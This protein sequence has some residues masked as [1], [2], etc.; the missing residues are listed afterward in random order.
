MDEWHRFGAHLHR[1]VMSQGHK[2]TSGKLSEY[3]A[4]V[5]PQAEGKPGGL[6]SYKKQV[7]ASNTAKN[8]EAN[9]VAHNSRQRFQGSSDWVSQIPQK[10]HIRWG[11][12]SDNWINNSKVFPDWGVCKLRL[13]RTNMGL[14]EMRSQVHYCSLIIV[15]F[16]STIAQAFQSLNSNGRSWVNI[17]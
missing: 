11:V 13:V 17:Y 3:L 2:T 16:E 5:S 14:C 10:G 4:V 6:W 1:H 8:S 12:K 7:T 15:I 9:V